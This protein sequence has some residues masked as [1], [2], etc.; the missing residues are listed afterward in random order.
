VLLGSNT[1]EGTLLSG[2]PVNATDDDYRALVSLLGPVYGPQALKRYPSAQFKSPFWAADAF[3]TDMSMACPSRFTARAFAAASPKNDVY[4]YQFN[5]E[6]FE[7]MSLSRNIGVCHSCELP[8]VWNLQNGSIALDG[9]MLPV[10]FSP[11]EAQLRD[12]ITDYWI[13]F[14]VH[15]EPGDDWP[16]YNA[17]ADLSRSL[18]LQEATVSGLKQANCDWW[19]TI[20]I[21]TNPSTQ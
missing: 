2:F 13:N 17:T 1:N 7:L 12:R 8:F 9:H 14:I 15:G 5:H 3:F 11:N 21:L 10:G 6:L 18:D 4:L 20:D 19:A 16:V